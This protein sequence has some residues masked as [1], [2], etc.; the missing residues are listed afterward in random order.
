[1]PAMP[2]IDQSLPFDLSDAAA[3]LHWR[4]R[5]LENYPKTTDAFVVEI[6]D[7]A[8]PSDTERKAILQLCAK[9]NMALYRVDRALGK[10][11][12]LKLANAFDL[13]DLDV[14]LYTGQPGVTEI[15]NIDGG[16][17]GEYAPYTDRAL[18]WHTDGYYNATDCQVLGMVLHCERQ[19]SDGG[20]SAL[21]DPEIAYIRLRDENP[22]LI[23]A[24]MEPDALTIPEN[25]ENDVLIRPA[26]TGPVFSVIGEHLH[27]R[28]SARKRYVEWK[29]G[30][31]LE[32]ARA[33]LLALLDDP[34]GPAIRYR[35]SA[36]EGLICNNVLHTRSAFQ[37][38]DGEGRLMLRARF[39]DRVRD[40]HEIGGEAWNT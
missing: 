2:K 37:D 33:F 9:T 8:M 23:A 7:P 1:L 39:R 29:S 22:D 28:F 32:K 35:L 17:Q 15:E 10:T 16:R 5:K 21:L 11:G 14:P 40:V 38:G 26:Q 36:G 31:T 13:K 19:A 4:G 24:L 20:E 25:V 3:Y 30:E 18:S 27:M 12:A 34:D 6:A